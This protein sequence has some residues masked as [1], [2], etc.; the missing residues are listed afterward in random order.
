M[1]PTKPIRSR[2]LTPA[3]V[4]ETTDIPHLSPAA[5]REGHPTTTLIRPSALS[6]I[7]TWSAHLSPVSTPAAILTRRH[8]AF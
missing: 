6:M 3:V 7:T 2:S 1:T 8:S 4:G 5:I